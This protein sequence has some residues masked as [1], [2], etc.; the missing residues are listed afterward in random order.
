MRD[1]IILESWQLIFPSIGIVLFMAVF[2]WVV[3]RAT[4]MKRPS[5]DRMLHLPMEQE[6]SRPASHVR[7]E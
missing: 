5:L 4:R 1:R 2:V 6:S 7:H 3:I